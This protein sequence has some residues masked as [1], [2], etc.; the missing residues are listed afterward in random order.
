MAT[1][2][3]IESIEHTADDGVRRYRT[4]QQVTVSPGG[5]RYVRSEDYFYWPTPAGE[6]PGPAR[7]NRLRAKRTARADCVLKFDD[8][9][10]AEAKAKRR[11]AKAAERARAKNKEPEAQ[12]TNGSELAKG[13]AQDFLKILRVPAAVKCEGAAAVAAWL[14]QYD[15]ASADVSLADLQGEALSAFIWRP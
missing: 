8:A 1:A 7:K 14:K 3:L 2:G 15:P 13:A 11:K 5:G 6:K 10:H 12:S 4:L 9:A